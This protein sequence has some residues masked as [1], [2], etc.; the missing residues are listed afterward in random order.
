[1]LFSLSPS[2]RDQVLT[3]SDC[4]H[5]SYLLQGQAGW[6][7]EQ[8]VLVEDVF[9]HCRDIGLEMAFKGPFQPKMF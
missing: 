6:S 4:S 1:M 2:G 8:A 3:V 7:S 5:Y 9:A